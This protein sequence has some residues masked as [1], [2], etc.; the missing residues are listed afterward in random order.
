[1]ILGLFVI[2]MVSIV[3]AKTLVA[4]KIYNEDY[5]KVIGGAEVTVTC[6]PSSVITTNPV[7]ISEA[8]GT[9]AVEFYENPMECTDGDMVTVYA[10]KDEMSGTETG[11]VKDLGLT[12]D[13][14]IINV[15]I[16]EFGL[17]IG[18]LTLLCAVGIFAFV[19]R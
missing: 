15:T 11:E 19:R 4:G 16:P 10:E 6:D 7:I 8:D 12:V 17:I 3:S 5:S 13:L 18:A 9:Y 1:M 14:A 2:S